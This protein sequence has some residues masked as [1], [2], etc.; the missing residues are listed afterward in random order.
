[1]KPTL[2][3][4]LIRLAPLSMTLLIPASA[5]AAEDCPS[6]YICASR[7]EG[8]V[9]TLQALGYKAMLGK[10]ET[11]GNPRIE[12]S[13]SGYDYEIFFYGCENGANCNSLGFMS[14][15]EKDAGNSASLANDWNREKRFSVMS[16]DPRDGTISISYDLT[17][18]G[19]LNQVNFSDAVAW[20]DAM[21]G[22]ARIFF[23]E[24][25]A[26]AK[27]DGSGGKKK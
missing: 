25:Q 5:L 14:T 6:S 11:T 10:S 26:S 13:S 3:A 23:K 16:Y 17:T 15:F 4:G 12:S 2:A 7:P 19:G 27:S 18:V 21:L 20:W 1:M 9:A 22:Q 8:I 24:R